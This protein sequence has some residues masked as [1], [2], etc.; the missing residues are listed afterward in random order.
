MRKVV[1]YLMFAAAL[2]PAQSDHHKVTKAD[3]DRWMTELSNWGRWGQ[4]DQ[5]GTLN[6]ITLAKRRD[7][8]ALVKEGYTI[9]MAHNVL[10]EKAVDNEYPFV[11]TMLPSYRRRSRGTRTGGCYEEALGF[12]IHCLSLACPRG[13]GSRINPIETY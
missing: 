10:T 8:I 7:A 4:D 5:L 9:S 3:I 1:I 13:T 2:M 6:L 12:S 11:H